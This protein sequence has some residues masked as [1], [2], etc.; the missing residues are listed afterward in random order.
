[1]FELDYLDFYIL[2]K[3]KAMKLTNE[4]IAILKDGKIEDNRFY[5]Q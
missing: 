5:L 2:K 1:M 3:N 4:Q